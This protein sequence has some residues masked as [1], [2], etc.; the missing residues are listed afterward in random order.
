MKKIIYLII[1][2]GLWSCIS[3]IQEPEGVYNNIS[4]FQA[5]YDQLTNKIF[6]QVTIETA[7]DTVADVRVQITA[8]DVPMDTMFILNDTAQ[9]GDL[10]AI[11][12]I[13]S[14]IFDI[15][16]PYQS[17][18]LRAVIQTQS[19]IELN[20]EKTIQVE[21]QFIPQIVDITFLKK[22]GV[23][24]CGYEVD[25]NNHYFINNED[26]S[27]LNFQIRIKDMNGL[28]NIESIRYETITTWFSAEGEE[29]PDCVEEC[30]NESPVYYM[31]N[32]ASND[33]MLTYEAINAYI[34]EPGFI[35]NPSSVCNRSG[36]ITFTFSAIDTFYG[37]LILDKIDLVFL[38]CNEGTWSS[39]DDC[40]HCPVECGECVE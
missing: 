35:I 7:N 3:E 19:G 24:E 29:C 31:T 4:N 30:L 18:Q 1:S 20:S 16:L 27:Y 6:F 21:E 2:I 38:N 36:V 13:Y 39:E 26:T 22:Y 37:P 5:D 17:Y 11:N 34:K 25:Y 10:I 9:D 12:G 40:E 8:N 14:G 23:D 28:D 15:F 32:I 33:S